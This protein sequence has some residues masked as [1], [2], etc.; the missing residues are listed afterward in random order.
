[1]TKKTS[2]PQPS[3][4]LDVSAIEKL[5]E[6]AQG[7][8]SG[9]VRMTPTE[10]KHTAKLKRG[11][12]QVL[13]VIAKLATKYAVQVP[14]AAT[15]DIMSNLTYAQ[16]LEP[17]IGSVGVLYETLRDA[18]SSSQSSSWKTGATAYGMMKKAAKANVSLSNELAPVTE[19]FRQRAKGDKPVA[20]QAAATPEAP[21][22]SPAVAQPAP[23]AKPGVAVPVTT[24]A[25]ASN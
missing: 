10:K 15:D 13:P 1:M 21:T 12:H 25:P 7:H 3:S 5:V 19:W 17:L 2:H 8:F 16:S 23:A 14:G 24:P 18:H 6:E 22:A 9:V 4:T 20:A 11:A